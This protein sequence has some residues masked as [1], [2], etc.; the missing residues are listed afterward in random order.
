MK[1][2]VRIIA[3]IKRA[4][5][6]FGYFGFYGEFKHLSRN[7]NS[8]KRLLI[9][10]PGAMGIP[11]QG[12]GA[13]ETII[14]ETLDMYIQGNYRVSL[15]NSMNIKH[16][17]QAQEFEFD[18]LLCHSDELV[19]RA[20]K[21]WPS[22]PMI[23]VSHYGMA[24]YP[25]E[26]HRSYMKTIKALARC[27]AV[28]CLNPT[29]EEKF[30]ELKVNNRLITSPNG[31]SF[32]PEVAT[33]RKSNQFVI[34]GKVE[35]RKRQFEVYQKAKNTAAEFI[36]IGKIEDP[37]V[38]TLI[39]ENLQAT[40]NFV[41]EWSRDQLRAR[42]RELGCLVLISKGEADALVL[43]EAQLAGLP[44][45]VTNRSIGSQNYNLPWVKII[46]EDFSIEELL[47]ASDSVSAEPA[48]IAE[49]AQ[50][51]YR[52]EIRN[53]E[54]MKIIEELSSESENVRSIKEKN[55]GRL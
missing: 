19:R 44:I 34:L 14:A 48:S 36:F 51:N 42:L 6:N 40:S 22:V 50:N 16:W 45:I 18:V 41:G 15:L 28:I 10:A 8:G 9:I 38:Q 5:R 2:Y 20:Y 1:N 25:E 39:S 35:E 3:R 4:L 12:W 55:M 52:W 54:L 11:T 21:Y 27:S 26:W 32:D 17:Q 37:K 31:S 53:I 33:L 49:Y 23:A 47:Q 29:I 43:Y 30:R 7:E 46:S 24:A 13:V